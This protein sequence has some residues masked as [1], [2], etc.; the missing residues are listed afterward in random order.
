MLKIGRIVKICG[1][2]L[3]GGVMAASSC[4]I[5][6]ITL[7][8]NCRCST[9]EAC[10]WFNHFAA[11]AAAGRSRRR[12]A[13]SVTGC[14]AQFPGIWHGTDA[15]VHLLHG[16]HHVVEFLC[17]FMFV[18]QSFQSLDHILKDELEEMR[19]RWSQCAALFWVNAFSVIPYQIWVQISLHFESRQTR[20]EQRSPL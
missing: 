12:L 17:A 11:F 14:F 4:T 13:A 15:A 19:L 2:K 20:R 16:V 18:S 3:N 10:Y 8:F 6:P 9:E 1:N 5:K 7:L